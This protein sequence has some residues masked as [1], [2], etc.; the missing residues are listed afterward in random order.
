MSNGAV[1]FLRY[2]TVET[3]ITTRLIKYWKSIKGI[4]DVPLE[5]DINYDKLSD[6]WDS[7]FILR[8]TEVNKS[9]NYSYD[10]IGD[11]I[12]DAYTKD[13]TEG[14]NILVNLEASLLHNR[15][16]EI[17]RKKRPIENQGTYINDNDKIIKFRQCMT[18]FSSNS[19]DVTTIIGAMK[20]KVI[21]RV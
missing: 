18:P 10:Y 19:K 6:I 17:I 13:L 3:R 4:N 8:V 9:I 20:Y 15:Y 7:C 2:T 1:D 21:T 16:L 12:R 11:N 14:N 5:K